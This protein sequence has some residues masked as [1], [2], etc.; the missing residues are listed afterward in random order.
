MRRCSIP[1]IAVTFLGGA[2]AYADV[3][4]VPV[5]G[6]Q[7]AGINIQ[8]LH[9]TP[10]DLRTGVGFPWIKDAPRREANDIAQ[11]SSIIY[12]AWPIDQQNGFTKTMTYNG[13]IGWLDEKAIRPLRRADGTTGGCT[14]FRRSDGRVMFHLDPGVGIN[15]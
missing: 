8:E 11:I 15:H 7:C 12:V 10:D 13:R 5:A 6:F 9:L 2:E 1:L 14:L 3:N 4:G